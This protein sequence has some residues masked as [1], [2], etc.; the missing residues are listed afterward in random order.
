MRWIAVHCH[1]LALDRAGRAW[2]DTQPLAVCDRLQVLQANEAAQALGVR[3]GVRRATAL[4]LS[5]GLRIVEHDARADA[6][7]LEQVAG[8][9]LQFTPGVSLEPPEDVLLEV[10][11]S[12]RLFGGLDRLEARIRDGLTA[13]G[14]RARLASAPTAAAARMLAHTHDGARIEHESRL[15]AELGPLPVER[16]GTAAPHVEA[17]AAIGVRRFADLARLPRAGLARRWGPALLDEVDAALGRR[18]EP[19]R[20][21]E[22]PERFALSLELLAQVEHA[23]ALLF[24]SQRMLAQFAGWLAGRQAAAREAVLEGLHDSGR[25]PCPPTRIELRLAEPSREAARWVGVLRE[26]LATITLPAPVHTLR[27]ACDRTV[28]LPGTHGELFPAAGTDAEGLGRLLERL[29]ARLGRE[30]VQRLLLAADHRPEVAYRV[31]PVDR[32]QRGPEVPLPGLPRPLWL[33]PEP[34]PLSERDQRPWWRGPLTLLAGPERIETGWWDDGLVQ[35]DYFI[36]EGESA[37]WLWIFRTRTNDDDAGWFL[38][39]LF[40]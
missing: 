9:L 39:G 12:L 40:G 10:E 35:R 4:A 14:F 33:L 20:W 17:L 36:A 6:D 27:L 22:A 32:P 3:P 21:F 24:A 19:R 8:W 13:L 38:Q 11:A 18:A 2:P 5:A 25:H 26:R 31:E 7:A 16:V 37:G 28:R 29:Q 30:R 15:A 34:V 1:R 23:E